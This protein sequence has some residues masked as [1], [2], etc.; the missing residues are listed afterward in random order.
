M[1]GFELGAIVFVGFRLGTKDGEGDFDGNVVGSE[2]GDGEFDGECV[3][4]T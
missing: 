4:S 3:G 1:E 2:D